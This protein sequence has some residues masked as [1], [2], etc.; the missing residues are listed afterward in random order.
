MAKWTL[1]YC[2]EQSE[3]WPIYLSQV[4]PWP[5]EFEYMER[6]N[7]EQQ[8]R[9]DPEN[10]FTDYRLHEGEAIVFGGSSQWHYRDRIIKSQEKNFCHLLFFHFIPEGTKDL[11]HSNRWAEYFGIPELKEVAQKDHKP[12]AHSLNELIGSNA[13]E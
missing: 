11:V 10:R 2:I 7:W 3:V 4:R 8:I 6:Q 1:G 13:K 9:D 5:E 12:V